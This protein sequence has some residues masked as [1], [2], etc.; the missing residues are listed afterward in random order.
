MGS[1]GRPHAEH[2]WR[3]PHD[4]DIRA[5]ENETPASRRPPEYRT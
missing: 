1:T 2:Q 5:E 4:H 3:M